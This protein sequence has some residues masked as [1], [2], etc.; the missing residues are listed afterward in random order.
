MAFQPS[1][2]WQKFCCDHCRSEHHHKH[3]SALMQRGRELEARALQAEE[4]DAPPS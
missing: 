4:P 1:R 2:P 3:T